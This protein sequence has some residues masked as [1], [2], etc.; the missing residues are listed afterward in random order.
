MLGLGVGFYGLSG[1]DQVGFQPSDIPNLSLHIEYTAARA[2]GSSVTSIPETFTQIGAD[3]KFLAPTS[4][5]HA[6][7]ISQGNGSELHP[8]V[9]VFSPSGTPDRLNLNDSSDNDLTEIVLDT[10]NGGYTVIF[11]GSG[12][13]NIL[14]GNNNGSSLTSNI[15][16]G[17]ST[18]SLKAGGVTKTFNVNNY[19]GQ[20]NN[21]VDGDDVCVIMFKV[22]PN[23]NTSLSIDNLAQINSSLPNTND[24]VFD[25]MGGVNYDGRFRYLFLY[26]RALTEAESNRIFEHVAHVIQKA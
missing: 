11:V 7:I 16:G 22:Q 15:G 13:S 9:V 10:S 2:D 23:G 24:F 4:T 21:E 18:Y 3:F 8:G 25:T 1:Q 14:S 6:P 5:A 20:A 26:D 12:G 17:A 19:S